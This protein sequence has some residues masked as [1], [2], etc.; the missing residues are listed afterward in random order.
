[1]MFT[2]QL[3]AQGDM[4]IRGTISDA[5]SGERIIGATV[6]EYDQT[7]R[8]ISG[9]ITDRTGNYILKVKDADGIFRISF[10]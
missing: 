2:Y 6:T 7:G 1:M 4:V 10:I 8:I 9:T 3:S 5:G